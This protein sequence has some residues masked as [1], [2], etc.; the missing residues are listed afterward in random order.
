[1]R[2]VDGARSLATPRRRTRVPA[3]IAG[4]PTQVEAFDVAGTTIGLVTVRDL[5]QHVDR[6]RLLHDESSVPPYWAMV[7][8]GARALAEHLATRVACHGA[9]VLD[10]GCGLG[11]VALAAAARGAVVTAIDRELAPIE[12]L[13]ASAAVNRMRI[14]A[15]VGDVAAT[16]SRDDASTWCS[17]PTCS[18]SARSSAGWRRRSLRWS[19]RR[20]TLWVADPQRV[21]TTEFYRE[22][23]A[24]GLVIREVCVCELREE[25]AL[26]RVRL[27]ALARRAGLSGSGSAA[28]ENPAAVHHSVGRGPVGV[29]VLHL[30]VEQDLAILGHPAEA[31]RPLALDEV[32]D[33]LDAVDGLPRIAGD[34]PRLQGHLTARRC[35]CCF[36]ELFLCHGSLRRCVRTGHARS[37]WST[38]GARR[39]VRGAR[40]TVGVPRIAGTPTRCRRRRWGRGGGDGTRQSATG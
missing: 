18:T 21:D 29:A 2:P 27:V 32:V 38:D 5:E 33:Q 30:V 1:M 4:F 14:E 11:L 34:V 10:V 7:W 6:E 13:Q 35:A 12:F 39:A 17:Q 23:D 16:R 3:I 25:G 22:L 26:L 37:G 20:G 9:T 36:A 31:R 15:L 19:H 8:G 24:R 40:G 28:A